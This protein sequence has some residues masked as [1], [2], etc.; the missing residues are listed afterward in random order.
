MVFFVISDFSSNIQMICLLS[1]ILERL[2]GE[3][4]HTDMETH[5]LTVVYLLPMQF[6]KRLYFIR[7]SV[8][9]RHFFQSMCV[10]YCVS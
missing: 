8:V 5:P 3:Q 1:A 10:M 2:K 9:G 7:F 4:A 6:V